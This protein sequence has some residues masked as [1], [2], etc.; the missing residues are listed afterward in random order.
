MRVRGFAAHV[1]TGDDMHQG[2]VCV[3]ANW[4]I[5]LLKTKYKIK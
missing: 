2:L 4:A 3:A 1:G 5:N